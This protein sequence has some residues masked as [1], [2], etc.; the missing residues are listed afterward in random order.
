MWSLFVRL[1]SFDRLWCHTASAMTSL[2]RTQKDCVKT[3]PGYTIDIQCRN[4]KPPKA[5]E[6]VSDHQVRTANTETTLM[7]TRIAV[8]VHSVWSEDLKA[9]QRFEINPPNGIKE[10]KRYSYRKT[11]WGKKYISLY[12]T[13][14]QR[15]DNIIINICSPHNPELSSSGIC[16]VQ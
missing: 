5:S 4:H 9:S 3:L 12:S 8:R 10:D 13:W 2:F 6:Q 16:S 1:R 7:Y 14:Q 15:V 11:K